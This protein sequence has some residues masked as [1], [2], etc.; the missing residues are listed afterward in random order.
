MER[1]I[2]I[3]IARGRPSGM[4]TIK[5]TTAIIVILPNVR[6]VSFENSDDSLHDK[7]RSMANIPCVTMLIKQAPQE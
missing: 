1:A 6:S 2:A 5:I 7:M 3:E 4:D